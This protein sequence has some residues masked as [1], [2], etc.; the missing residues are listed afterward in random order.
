MVC[1]NGVG[2][3][4]AGKFC[5]SCAGEAMDELGGRK[6]EGDLYVRSC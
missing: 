2:G 5:C 1:V 6:E 3:A 4:N